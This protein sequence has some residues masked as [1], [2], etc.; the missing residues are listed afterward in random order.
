MFPGDKETEIISSI[1]STSIRKVSLVYRRPNWGASWRDVNWGAFN[2]PLCRL[3]D[4][5]GSAH[6]LEVE[7]L[8]A[9]VGG[10]STY[11]DI[12]LGVIMSP[13]ATFR[14][15]GRIR[16]VYMGRSGRAHVVYPLDP[17]CSNL[18]ASVR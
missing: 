15:K 4:R 13:L 7:I 6:E 3:V 18:P 16:V 12:D 14:E 11:K 8:I 5:L 17:C 9:D 2:E 1:T 10:G